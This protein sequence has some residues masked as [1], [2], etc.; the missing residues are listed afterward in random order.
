M[1][2]IEK[3]LNKLSAKEKQKFKQILFQ[4]KASD[5]QGLNLKKLRK[6]H[7]I[8]R[9]RKGNMRII[10]RKENDSI[11]ILTLERKSSKTYKKKKQFKY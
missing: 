3:A 1:D 11:K 5:F 8:F 4:I 2:K 7:D 10:F 9:V 6:R